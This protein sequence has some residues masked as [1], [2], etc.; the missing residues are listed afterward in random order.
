MTELFTLP[1]KKRGAGTTKSLQRYAIIMLRVCSFVCL[2]TYG[3]WL[4]IWCL[5]FSPGWY[6]EGVAGP[7]LWFR[8]GP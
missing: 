2:I 7:C 1:Y 4:T 6:I 8:G 5:C 3:V